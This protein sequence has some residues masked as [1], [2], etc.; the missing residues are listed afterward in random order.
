MKKKLRKQEKALGMLHRLIAESFPEL[1]GIAVSLVRKR[2]DDAHADYEPAGRGYVIELDTE[3]PLSVTEGVLAHELAHIVRDRKL[4]RVA[5]VK[6]RIR[7]ATS[8]RYQDKDEEKTTK[9]AIRRGCG[10]AVLR[11][12]EYEQKYYEWDDDPMTPKRIRALIKEQ[13][14]A[15]EKAAR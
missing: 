5:R 9:E 4:S 12:A 6:D 11:F 1:R 7:Y 10:P 8:Q 2:K 3:P 13:E 14:S 15:P